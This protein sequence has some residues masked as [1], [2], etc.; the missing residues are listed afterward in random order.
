MK[1]IVC[2][3]LMILCI[4][5]CFSCDT[6][7]GIALSDC[8]CWAI[9][10]WC[11]PAVNFK[12]WALFTSPTTQCHVDKPTIADANTIIVNWLNEARE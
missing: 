7:A 8:Q 9:W 5:V 2:A 11:K 4:V 1:S 10:N 3:T 12:T 6:K